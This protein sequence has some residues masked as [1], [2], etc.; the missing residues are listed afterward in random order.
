MVLPVYVAIPQVQL[1]DKVVVPVVCTTNALIQRCTTVEVPQ[2]QFLFMVVNIPVGTQSLIPMA[3][4]VQQTINISR[5]QFLDKELTCPLLGHTGASWC[6]TDAALGQG[7]RARCVH[8]KC[9]DPEVHH[10]GGAAG[11]VPLHGPQHPC[12][13]AETASHGVT[14]QRPLGFSCSSTLTKWLGCASPA[15]FFDAGHCRSHACCCATTGALA[16]RDSALSVALRSWHSLLGRLMTCPLACRLFRAVNTGTR[17]G[18]SPA[19]RAE[20]GWRGR[21]ELAPRCSAT[22][23]GAFRNEPGQTRRCLQ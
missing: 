2:L 21:R 22:Q 17:P 1:L 13:C 8:D 20:K 5:L 15:T 4:T 10:S 14:F 12:R 7:C 18:L 19:I 3:L 16:G 23:L 9:P 6:S 11:A